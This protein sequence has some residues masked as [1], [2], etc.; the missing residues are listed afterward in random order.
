LASS[1]PALIKRRS[2][3][4]TAMTDEDVTAFAVPDKPIIR[5]HIAYR[6]RVNE[7]FTATV[8]GRP[9]VGDNG[10]ESLFTSRQIAREEALRRWAMEHN[11]E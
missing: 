5:T 10:A 11:H 6:N 7:W 1:I 9:L 2:M 4:N 8:N 3:R